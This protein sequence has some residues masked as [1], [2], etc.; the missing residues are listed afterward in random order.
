MGGFD[1]FP[2]GGKLDQH[3]RFVDTDGFVELSRSVQSGLKSARSTYFNDMKGLVDGPFDIEGETGIHFRR[4]SSR[5]NLQDLV[6]EFNEQPVK[7]C[8]HFLLNGVSL[9]DN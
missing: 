3:A 4:D 2:G 1:T 8:V 7:C 5:N 9:Q 6:A